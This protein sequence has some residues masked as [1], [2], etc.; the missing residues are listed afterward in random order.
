MKYHG[1][2]RQHVDSWL[3]ILKSLY[4]QHKLLY[5]C[6][7]YKLHVRGIYLLAFSAALGNYFL[8]SLSEVLSHQLFS[9]NLYPSNL[10][11]Q[12]K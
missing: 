6:E 5:E 3:K 4:S 11:E 9:V 1:A 7:N 8:F 12:M 2:D 10:N